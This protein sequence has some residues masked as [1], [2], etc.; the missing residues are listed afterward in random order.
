MDNDHERGHPPLNNVFDRAQ[1]ERDRST[2]LLAHSQTLLRAA[3]E[4]VERSR[5][6]RLSLAKAPGSGEEPAAVALDPMQVKEEADARL[7]AMEDVVNQM[8]DQVGALLAETGRLRQRVA[9]M[10]AEVGG[11]RPE[12]GRRRR[13]PG[14][15]R[16]VE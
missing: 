8:S 12:T 16:P 9:E 6:F 13:K 1:R 10:E 11:S 7:A 2:D 4:A 5:A 14:H 3:H 15:L